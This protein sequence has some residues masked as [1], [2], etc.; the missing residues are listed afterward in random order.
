MSQQAVEAVI[1]RLASDEAFRERFADNRDAAL[2]ELAGNGSALTPVERR[3]LLGIDHGACQEFAERLDPRLQKAGLR[4]FRAPLGLEEASAS[5]RDIEVFVDGRGV[6][7]AGTIEFAASLAQQHGAHLTGV[8]LQP[9]PVGSPNE[10]FARGQAMR[11]VIAKRQAHLRNVEADCRTLF[12]RMLGR[13]G[14]LP[15]WRSIPWFSDS[16]AAVHARYGDLAVVAR[17]QAG[18][19]MA[20]SAGVEE[21]LVLASGRPII[22]LPPPGT[23]PG[24]RRIL[25]AWNGGREAARAVADAMPL[26][27]RAEAVEVLFMDE[28]GADLRGHQPGADIAR[29]LARHQARVEV[30]RLPA[31]GKDPGSL[32]LS[33]AADFGADL[34]VMGAYGHSRLKERVL[35]GVTR[36]ALRE[37]PLPVLMSR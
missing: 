12:N 16:E 29:H 32:L 14:I 18:D 4:S 36:T 2:D 1:G 24:L 21:S 19:R 10:M 8:F 9:D 35:G 23:R 27:A 7:N 33:R 22:V 28:G 37:A 11:G 30:R 5:F 34:L 17:R 26:L 31:Q 6:G 13:H 25:V 3:A 20:G 15:E